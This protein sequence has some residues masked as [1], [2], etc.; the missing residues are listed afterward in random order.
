MTGSVG[1]TFRLDPELRAAFLAACQ[2]RDVSAA[3]VLRGAMRD[4]LGA[5]AQGVLPLAP[6]E[7]PTKS[8]RKM[9]K[10]EAD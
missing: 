4:F 6:G 1:M 5:N 2:A 7:A 10:G 8:R 3:Q 9:R